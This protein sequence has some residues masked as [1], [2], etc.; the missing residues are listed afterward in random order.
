MNFEKMNKALKLSESCRNIII[1][2]NSCRRVNQ[3]IDCINILKL[4]KSDNNENLNAY[5]NYIRLEFKIDT[6]NVKSFDELIIMLKK[7]NSNLY[8]EARNICFSELSGAINEKILKNIFGI[9]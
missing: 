7:I 9:K 3:I 6:N 8:S 2:N 1:L 4:M 5:K